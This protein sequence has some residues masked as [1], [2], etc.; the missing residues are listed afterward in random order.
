M[1]K[2]DL[3]SGY[4]LLDICLHNNNFKVIFTIRSQFSAYIFTK[5]PKPMAKFWR[6][7]GINIV[8]YLDD[9]IGMSYSI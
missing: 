5:C 1:F 8:L 9:G 6:Q 2:F 7:S 3:K 4:D